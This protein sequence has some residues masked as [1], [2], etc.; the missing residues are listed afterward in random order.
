MIGCRSEAVMVYVSYGTVRSG[1]LLD[2]DR[3]C[4]SL[5]TRWRQIRAVLCHPE[6]LAA[7]TSL[8]SSAGRRRWDR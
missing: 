3:V 7:M 8:V 6:L 1:S 2:G 5:R 4:S